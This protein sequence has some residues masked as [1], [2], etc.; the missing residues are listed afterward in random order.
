M[1]LIIHPYLFG[2]AQDNPILQLTHIFSSAKTCGMNAT[3]NLAYDSAY[4]VYKYF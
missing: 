2:G 4:E 1:S 3:E